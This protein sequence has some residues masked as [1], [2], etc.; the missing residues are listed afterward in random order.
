VGILCAKLVSKGEITMNTYMEKIN[1]L[2]TAIDFEINENEEL[3]LS[4]PE[5][6]KKALMIE[7]EM[8]REN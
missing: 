4:S 1:E 7:E 6:V 2:R 3:I 8:S 5:L